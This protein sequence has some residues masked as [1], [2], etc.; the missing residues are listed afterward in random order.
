MAQKKAAARTKNMNVKF[1]EE[2]YAKLKE[3]ADDLGGM[4]L[5]SLIRMLVCG[6]I[7]KVNETEN[8]ADF[9]PKDDEFSKKVSVK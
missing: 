2:D 9:L 5:S 6:R 1:T 4:S 3:I 8:A 7:K